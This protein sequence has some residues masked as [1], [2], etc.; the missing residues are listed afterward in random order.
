MP[1]NVK[2]PD[3]GTVL[4]KM[5]TFSNTKEFKK[6]DW[7]NQAIPPIVAPKVLVDKFNAEA[8]S[9]KWSKTT[10]MIEILA[11]HYGV[12]LEEL[13]NEND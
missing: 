10:L 6:R 7:K 9:K 1:Q 2:K 11:K 3:Q 4:N 13:E 8:K 5:A 12:N